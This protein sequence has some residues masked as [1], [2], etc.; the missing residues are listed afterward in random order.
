[1]EAKKRSLRSQ[2][3]TVRSAIAATD[4]RHA[5]TQITARLIER[6]PPEGNAHVLLYESRSEWNEVDTVPLHRE[7]VHRFP[8]L[9]VTFAGKTADASLPEGRFD[10]IV[11]PVLGFD[12]SC[13][14]LGLGGGWYDRLLAS[15]SGAT[16]VGL[17]YERCLVEAVPVEPHDV[18]L[19]YVITERTVYRR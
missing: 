8:G 16:T 4:V 5:S 18:P 19:D 15:Q 1:M 14:R 7:L 13:N 17:A 10:Y 2:L 11:V 6:V 3:K 12:A 9:V